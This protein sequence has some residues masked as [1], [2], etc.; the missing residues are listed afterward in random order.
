MH[1]S[2][3][4][5]YSPGPTTV[6]EEFIAKG[7]KEQ[8][9]SAVEQLVEDEFERLREYGDE[10]ISQVAAI[11]AERFLERVLN[12]DDDAAMA[13][14]GDK[15]GG[16]RYRQDGCNHGKPWAN[17]I[18]GRLFESGGV[19]LRRRIVEAHAELL[20]NERIADLESVVA[21]LTQQVREL[22][23]DLERCRERLSF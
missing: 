19:A 13:L 18:N 1:I 21:G 7:R 5:E 8:I 12:G 14:L 16:S 2:D 9:K 4:H 20:R 3:V 22:I 23:A 6:V 15:H 10:Y 11:R 17:L